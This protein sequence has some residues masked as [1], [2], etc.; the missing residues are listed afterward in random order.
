MN[1]FEKIQNEAFSLLEKL[2]GGTNKKIEAAYKVAYNNIKADI[3]KLYDKYAEDGVLSYTELAKYDRLT[4]I[5]KQIEDELKTATK[6]IKPITI[7]AVN[8]AYELGTFYQ[9]YGIDMS[10]NIS[11]SWGMFNKGAVKAA[12]MRDQYLKS[13]LT[14][15]RA[16]QII[17]VKDKI[18]QALIT[19]DFGIRDLTKIINNAMS[20]GVASAELIAQTETTAAFGRAQTALYAEAAKQG[21][22]LIEEWDTTGGAKDP[23]HDPIEKGKQRQDDGLFHLSSGS[24]CSSPGNCN[25]AKDS[26]RCRC[27]ILA[28]LV[29]YDL[30]DSPSMPYDEWV[31]KYK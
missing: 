14:D 28:K 26:C 15:A 10:L 19:G 22:N 11:G 5:K 29:G 21:V 24:T 9:A 27:R 23:R 8:G 4:A 7:N 3:K 17:G 13:F 2:Q 30:G 31:K 1:L 20:E 16:R 25:T 12:I 6:A 18:V